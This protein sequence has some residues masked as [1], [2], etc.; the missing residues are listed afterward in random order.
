MRDT[1]VDY[2]G[3]RLP[4]TCRNARSGAIAALVAAILTAT[5]GAQIPGAPV[6]QNAWATPGTVGAV[7]LGGGSDGSVYA[8]A[9][10]W[11]PGSGRFQL[12]GGAGFQSRAGANGRGV[13]GIRGAIPL[14][15]GSSAVGFAPFVGVGGGV[16]RTT[17]DSIAEPCLV[18]PPQSCLSGTASASNTIEVPVGLAV[19]WRHAIGTTHGLSLYAT[20]SYVFF[21]GGK[22]TSGGLLRTAIGADLGV[23]SSIGA[24]LGIEFGGKRPRGFGGPSGSVY[25][26]GLSYALGHR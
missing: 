20:P 18:N 15:G 21:S 7:D 11:T 8:A 13:Y 12:S 26:L 4:R 10:S 9:A 23:T 1:A 25:G 2:I 24:T 3:T 19:G 6:L 17:T 14:G 22:G 5:S 16:S